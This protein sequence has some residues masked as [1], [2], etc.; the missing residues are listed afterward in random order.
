MARGNKGD[1][2]ILVNPR[3]PRIVGSVSRSYEF[4]SP[5]R[6]RPKVLWVKGI[7][8]A[9]VREYWSSQGELPYEVCELPLY[10]SSRI[11]GSHGTYK[12][13]RFGVT[14]KMVVYERTHPEIRLVLLLAAAFN[15]EGEPWQPIVQSNVERDCGVDPRQS[16]QLEERLWD[17]VC[18]VE[19]RG[20]PRGTGH[21]KERALQQFPLSSQHVACLRSEGLN[22]KDL[23][24][25]FARWEQKS[26]KQIGREL[27]ISAQAVWKRWKRKIEPA[28]KRMNPRF[29][30]SSFLLSSLDS[31]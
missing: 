29:S 22:D 15:R 19:R 21:P 11:P 27:G 20:R 2:Q 30:R 26:Y 17:E 4:S 9:M 6:G 23:R 28:I 24:I 7:N 1:E 13:Y 16:K 14:R 31:K 25:L 12:S 3:L 8:P 5:A 18:R 10:I